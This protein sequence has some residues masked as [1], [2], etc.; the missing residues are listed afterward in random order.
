MKPRVGSR[1][2]VI[3]SCFTL[4]GLSYVNL[5]STIISCD[6]SHERTVP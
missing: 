3:L 5:S 2:T 6:E 1:A 4:C